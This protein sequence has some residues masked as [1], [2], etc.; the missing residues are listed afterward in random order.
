MLEYICISIILLFL[1]PI[2]YVRIR[3]PFWSTQPVFHT[4]DIFR[5]LAR[6]PYEI[7]QSVY[8]KMHKLDPNIQT[9]PFLDMTN[10]KKIELVQFIQDHLVESDNVLTLMDQDNLHNILTGQFYPSYVSFYENT[11]YSIVKGDNGEVG[12]KNTPQIIGCMTSRGINMFILDKSG[13]LHEKNGYFWDNICVHREYTQENI[14]RKLIQAHD[15]HQRTNTQPISISLFKKEIDLCEGVIPLVEYPVHTFTLSKIKRPP[16]P[17][18]YSVSRMYNTSVEPFYNLLYMI[19]H[20]DTARNTAFIAFP[21]ISVLDNMI[22]NNILFVYGLSYGI[23]IKC[24][25]VFKNPQLCYD[26]IKD[27]HILECITTITEEYVQDKTLNGLIFAGFLHALQHIQKSF[28]NKYK[29]ITF[30]NLGQNQTIIERWKWKYTPLSKNM[31]AYYLYNG[32]IPG[33]PIDKSNCIII[34]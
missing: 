15:I 22:Q 30:H 27:G 34:T 4:Y 25:Y 28:S 26:N 29:I 18:P 31:A 20:S 24:V 21:E 1:I 14:G 11:K 17:A 5:Y 3:Y 7:H 10:N 16:L 12:I 6:T 33:M 9:I 32:V 13:V 23:N 2:I 19:S 8:S